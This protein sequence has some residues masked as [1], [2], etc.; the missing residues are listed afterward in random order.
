M[1]SRRMAPRVEYFGERSDLAAVYKLCG[2]AI[3][4]GLAGT[5]ADVFAIASASDV[6]PND[7]LRCSTSSTRS[8][9]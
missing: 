9:S 4:V 3:I 1:I 8:R 2:N 7:T 6:V 5:I